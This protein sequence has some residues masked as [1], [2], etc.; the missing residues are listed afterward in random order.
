[1]VTRNENPI[2]IRNRIS[3]NKNVLWRKWLVFNGF[4]KRVLYG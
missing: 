4:G 1:M 2:I 3:F